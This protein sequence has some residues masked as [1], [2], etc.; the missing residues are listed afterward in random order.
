MGLFAIDYMA[1]LQ[2]TAYEEFGI[3][4]LSKLPAEDVRHKILD[5]LELL[6]E[7]RFDEMFALL[8]SNF[9]T[10][11]IDANT[12]KK[13]KLDALKKAFHQQTTAHVNE[14]V[15]KF[16]QGSKWTEA[17][18]DA[19]GGING[20]LP[21]TATRYEDPFDFRL[22][23]EAVS[24]IQNTIRETGHYHDFVEK[25]GQVFFGTLPTGDVNAKVIKTPQANAYLGLFNNGLFRFTYLLGKVIGQALD[26]SADRKSFGIPS[27]PVEELVARRPHLVRRLRHLLGAYVISGHPGY[28]RA[29]TTSPGPSYVASRVAKCMVTFLIGHEFGH[30]IQG[31]LDNAKPARTKL[32]GNDVDELSFDHQAEFGADFVALDL[33]AR[34]KLAEKETPILIEWAPTLLFLGLHLVRN[35]FEVLQTGAEQED[36]ETKS[37]PTVPERLTQI[38]APLFQSDDPAL[39]PRRERANW[40]MALMGKLWGELKPSFEQGHDLL[41]APAKIWLD[42]QHAKSRN[43]KVAIYTDATR[44]GAVPCDALTDG[45]QALAVGD[46]IWL[47]GDRHAAA[48]TW[49]RAADL[50]Q[51]KATRRLG[52]SKHFDPASKLYDP[53]LEDELVFS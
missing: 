47:M 14:S 28:S 12:S 35:G 37:H 20:L 50:G 27:T 8:A 11:E 25:S 3:D 22:V 2:K 43:E 7:E 6:P 26:Y 1:S 45:D 18:I 31:D 46:Y 13:A 33:M 42:E 39:A 40:L 49:N 53:S 5:Q 52:L 9:D 34:T 10:L 30:V 17:E 21:D 24:G 15:V 16:F 29:Y 4:P 32:L 38:V 19:Q 41:V 23:A 44:I 48:A 36:P 51:E